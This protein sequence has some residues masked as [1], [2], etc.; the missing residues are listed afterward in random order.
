LKR[1]DLSKNDLV[2]IRPLEGLHSLEYLDLSH[3]S[4]SASLSVFTSLTHLVFLDL[5]SN[6][7]TSF[8]ELA[9]L[10][11]DT[12][13]PNLRS[14]NLS[15]NP[16][17]NT[18]GYP[19]QVFSSLQNI[20][21]VDGM[22]REMFSGSQKVV[23]SADDFQSS[24]STIRE[25]DVVDANVKTIE[26]LE[27][28][29]F[30][31]E[32]AFDLQ[33]AALSRD[34][35]AVGS[36]EVGQFPFLQLLQMWR[37]KALNCMA[38]SAITQKTAIQLEDELKSL[39]A[40]HNRKLRE[41]QLHTLS[42]KERVG[43]AE[44][45]ATHL[46]SQCIAK[47]K[48]IQLLRSEMKSMEQKVA[49]EK[50]KVRDLGLYLEKAV[51]QIDSKSVGAL[52][53]ADK[54]D[55]KLQAM[56]MRLMSASKRVAFATNVIAQNEISMRNSLALK[57]AQSRM[58]CSC[59][60]AMT[61]HVSSNKNDDDDVD[62]INDN[63]ENEKLIR[64]ESSSIRPE[65]EALLRA[66]FNRIDESNEGKVKA[67]LVH[68][69]ISGGG[70]HDNAADLVSLCKD[71][72]G[73]SLWKSMLNTLSAM[74]EKIEITWGEMLLLLIPASNTTTAGANLSV[75][76]F[77]G[78]RNAGVWSDNDWGIV[79]FNID[80]ISKPNTAITRDT[81]IVRLTAERSYLLERIQNM[82]R[83]LERRVETA[84]VYFEG[85][86]RRAKMKESRLVETVKELRS[87]EDILSARLEETE[88]SYLE[89]KALLGTN[90]AQLTSELNN[91]RDKYVLKSSDEL[92]QAHLSIQAAEAK[93]S[94]LET[95][96]SILQKELSKRDIVNKGLQRDVLRVQASL[97]ALVLE[98]SRIE[99]EFKRTDDQLTSVLKEKNALE[100][101]IEQYSASQ[102]K[103]YADNSEDGDN[104][105]D[106]DDDGIQNLPVFR[107]SRYDDEN[108]GELE[109]R[110]AADILR[111]Q[112][113]KIKEMSSPSSCR[114]DDDGGGGIVEDGK[115]ANSMYQKSDVY[116]AHLDKLLRLAEEA[117]GE[118]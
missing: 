55:K 72:L 22:T 45:K 77:E 13:L 70:A 18:I 38:V 112:M 28:R 118:N 20:D 33:E 68:T 75:V 88:S 103:R 23:R 19:A 3:N 102:Q 32:E 59:G 11:D 14:I 44:Q 21:M 94:R 57:D 115:D 105:G 43:A 101:Q 76:E 51:H 8:D 96:Q 35:D 90:I 116:A 65:A 12:C 1:L 113:Q 53:A 71:T 64:I 78:L 114:S 47:E 109:E 15:G 100:S 67:H 61:T 50:Q 84:K 56:Q 91:M 86:L 31:M 82:T 41:Y 26:F 24:R 108:D 25:E 2:D 62:N 5:S 83:T 93:I 54:A 107:Q 27:S 79:A 66:I 4:I 87:S 97:S 29:L 81:E 40:E 48:E 52:L 17:C 73:T 74:S 69:V 42:H 6:S 111:L 34:A 106:G 95:E 58:S 37:N 30:K 104:S 63:D 49:S 9:A 99:E 110:Q 89:S 117:I 80:T 16:V 92:K 85:D 7:I 46:E 39:R 10:S 98:K 36:A 60:A